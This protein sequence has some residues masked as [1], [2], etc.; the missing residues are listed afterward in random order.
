MTAIKL[1]EWLRQSY[2][3]PT[4]RQANLDRHLLG[5]VPDSI[6]EFD[7]FYEARRERLKARTKHLL[8][9]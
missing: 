1:C 3:D 4:S 7:A 6:T 8:G 9:K 5:E 2:P